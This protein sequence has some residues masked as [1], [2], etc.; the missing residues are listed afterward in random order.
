MGHR[1]NFPVGLLRTPVATDLRFV[2]YDRMVAEV[3]GH[4]EYAER[5]E[6]IA[7]ALQRALDSGKPSLVNIA[8]APGASPMAEA[9]IARRRSS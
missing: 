2:R 8:V 3:G 6:E 7:P 4:G 5:S 9:M 1:Q